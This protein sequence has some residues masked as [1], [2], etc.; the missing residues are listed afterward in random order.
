MNQPP[1]GPA[2]DYAALAADLIGRANSGREQWCTPGPKR[3]GMSPDA[4]AAFQ[5]AQYEHAAGLKRIVERMRRWPGRSTVGPEACQAAVD[6]AVH[7][8]HDPPLQLTLLRLLKKAVDSGEATTAQLAH[9]YDRWLV[10][11]KQKQ[12]YGTQHWYRADGSLAPHPITDRDQLDIRRAAAGLPP[13]ADQ[14]RRLR[15]HHNPSTS[16]YQPAVP[17]G[18][19]GPDKPAAA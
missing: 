9:L 16:S 4:L 5:R 19:G 7:A 1:Q 3:L 15:E 12:L 18:A 14:T 8:D 17:Q 13:Y 2:P 11:T 10:N 6:I